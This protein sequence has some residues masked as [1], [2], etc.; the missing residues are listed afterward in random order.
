QNE[1]QR[2]DDVRRRPQ[3][4]FALGERFGNQTEFVVLEIAQ[5]AVDQLGALRGRVRGEVVLLEEQ[6]LE[7][8]SGRV[9][10]DAGAVDAAAD[11][12]DV[13]MRGVGAGHQKG[14]ARASVD[15][16]AAPAQRFF[17]T[18]DGPARL[19]P[20]E[21]NEHHARSRRPACGDEGMAPPH[22]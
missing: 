6:N 4:Y 8:P 1:L 21:P 3:Q 9:A 13:V 16:T 20:E 22:S 11:D 2:G 17:A 5:A 12:G 14:P 7:S 18:I 19:Y 15:S 10:S